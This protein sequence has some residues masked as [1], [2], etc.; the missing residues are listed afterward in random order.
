MLS[1]EKL[2]V[3]I[4]FYGKNEKKTVFTLLRNWN[5][6]IQ[7]PEAIRLSVWDGAACG[8]PAHVSR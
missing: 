1:A 5:F 3:V 6:S 2:Y 7:A 8:N 4:I